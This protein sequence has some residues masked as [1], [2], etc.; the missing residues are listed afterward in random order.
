MSPSSMFSQSRFTRRFA[1]HARVDQRGFYD[2]LE[3]G[4]GLKDLGSSPFAAVVFLGF[5]RKQETLGLA[6]TMVALEDVIELVRANPRTDITKVEPILLMVSLMSL[7]DS[8]RSSTV[9]TG[10]I[11][12][13]CQR[14]PTYCWNM[15][16]AGSASSTK[17]AGGAS[18]NPRQVATIPL[19]CHNPE[20]SHGLLLQLMRSSIGTALRWP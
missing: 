2:L 20:T 8:R 3:D 10:S 11:L 16:R 6:E 4:T 1:T 18:V 7:H 12:T 19:Q 13:C 9:E 5:T 17:R 14:V 15:P